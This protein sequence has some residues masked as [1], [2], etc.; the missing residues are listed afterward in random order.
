[1]TSTSYTLLDLMIMLPNLH[2]RHLA[3]LDVTSIN[4]LRL[5]SK[6]IGILALTAVQRCSVHLGV[7][8][9]RP[10]FP[11]PA[12]LVGLMADAQLQQL[13]VTLSLVSGE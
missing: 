3:D 9:A 12:Q 10:P 1:M 7:R 13:Y 4:T 8:Q 11:Q 5:V 2:P 6:D